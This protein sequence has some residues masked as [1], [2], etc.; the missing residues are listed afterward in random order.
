MKRES[1]FARHLSSFLTRYLPGTLNVSRNT[2]SAYRD[3]YKL[4]LMFWEEEKKVRPEHLRLDMITHAS[5]L[6]FLAWLENSRGC[7]IS[8][9]NHRLAALH[10]FFRYVQ[11]E[12]P[13]NLFELQKVLGIPTKKGPRPDIKFLTLK[14]TEILLAQS[15]T[16]TPSGRRNLALFAL[17]YDSGA[18]VQEIIDLTY[19]DV[20]LDTP[21]VVILRG[22]GSKTRSVPIMKNTT[23]LLKEYMAE[24]KSNRRALL[25]DI[26]L[27]CNQQKQKFTRKGIAYVLNK[28]V[29]YASRNPEFRRKEKVT[30]HVL[31]HS[32][33][34]H[35]LQAGIPLIYI[36]DFL[37][38]A[39]VKST[40]I[41][42]RLNDEIKRKAIEEAYIDL[43]VPEFP[44][45]QENADLMDWLINFCK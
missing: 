42:A 36:R 44:S 40:E 24:L 41:Y 16:S 15:N 43:N 30:C 10:S 25:N 6:D 11:K 31:R 8:T 26:P 45:W 1:D 3:T 37:G 23:A 18:R 33:A 22:K 29:E 28:Y 13:E 5:V 21:S 4:F 2:I 20:R 39:S 34:A 9:R 32:R 19:E 12:C 14:E 17:M 35:M 7:S 27:F 38:H